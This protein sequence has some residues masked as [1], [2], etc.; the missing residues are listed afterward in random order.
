M[1][2][3]LRAASDAI[4]SLGDPRPG[5]QAVAD[6]LARFRGLGLELVEET[7]GSPRALDAGLDVSAYRI[8]QEALTNASR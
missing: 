1:L 4:D 7:A 5:L 3:L 6:L 2:G 8:I